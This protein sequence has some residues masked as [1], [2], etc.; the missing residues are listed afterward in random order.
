MLVVIEE[1]RLGERELLT[2]LRL[3][4]GCLFVAQPRKLCGML[5]PAHPLEARR[6]R[7]RYAVPDLRKGSKNASRKHK[8]IYAVRLPRKLKTERPGQIV[9]VDTVHIGLA[10]GETIRHFTGYCPIAKERGDGLSACL[11]VC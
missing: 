8:R 10:P 1:R 2:L 4:F 9:Q 6:P 11:M 7:R 5:V 3:A